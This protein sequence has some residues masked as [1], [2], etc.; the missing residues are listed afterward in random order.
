M[1]VYDISLNLSTDTV[2]WVFAP[3]LEVH[4]RRRMSRGDDANA[5]A[6][7]VSVHAGTHVDAPFHFLP[8]FLPPG[9]G[10]VL[11]SL[12]Q[13]GPMIL[14]VLVVSGATRYI[15]G[16]VFQAMTHFYVAVVKL[17]L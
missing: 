15:V 3:P 11:H 13:F 5:S 4:E 7:T 12:E 10:A 14:L 8:Y 6:L 16:P 2:R 9:A 1:R 17:F